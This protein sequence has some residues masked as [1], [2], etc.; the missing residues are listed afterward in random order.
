MRSVVAIENS[1]TIFIQSYLFI[2]ALENTVAPNFVMARLLTEIRCS[3]WE[4]RQ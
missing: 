2:F 3:A 4:V 1:F